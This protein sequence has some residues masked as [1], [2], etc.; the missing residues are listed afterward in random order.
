MKKF[1]KFFGWVVYFFFSIGLYGSEETL[2]IGRFLIVIGILCIMV[3]KVKK[4]KSNKIGQVI[5]PDNNRNNNLR[6]TIEPLSRMSDDE[7]IYFYRKCT[8]QANHLL[9]E[10]ETIDDFLETYDYLMSAKNMLE[11]QSAIRLDKTAKSIK[12]ILSWDESALSS[13]VS[14]FIKRSIDDKKL[15]KNADYINTCINAYKNSEYTDYIQFTDAVDSFKRSMSILDEIEN[16]PRMAAILSSENKKYI[17][18]LRTSIQDCIELSKEVEEEGFSS[19]ENMDSMSG[20]EF[21]TWCAALLLKNGFSKANVTKASGDHG[22]DIVAEKDGIYYAI[23]CK[24]YHSDLGNAPVQEV[25][26]GKEMYKCQVGV[27]MTNRHFTK[28]ARELAEST[29]V[30]LWD[31]DKLIS[32]I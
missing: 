20:T 27:V 11:K 30:L 2:P 1:L 9:A 4:S 32:M 22:V 8:T 17:D 12:N 21:E 29:R 24:C 15:M 23:Q 28:G 14:E 25:Y 18:G 5:L 26:A 31:R 16:N 3:G 6:N 13:I 19:A 7:K 10:T